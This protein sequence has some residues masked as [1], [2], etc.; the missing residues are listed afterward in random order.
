MVVVE[1]SAKRTPTRILARGNFSLNANGLVTLLV[2]L[3]I[4]TL[5]LAAYLALNGYWPVL[6]IAALQLILV[7]LILIRAWKSA[8]VFEEI[9]F[10]ESQIHVMHQQYQKRHHYCLKAA[11]AT[12]GMNKTGVPW[13][14][15]KLVLRSAKQAV[16]LGAF[17]TYEEKLKLVKHL[18]HAL[19]ERSAWRTL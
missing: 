13:H 3:G 16:E 15:P 4:V 2:S 9:Y 6:V 19:A 11:W 14:A 12:V 7:A 10:D 5:G 1:T 18:S 17:L 8:W